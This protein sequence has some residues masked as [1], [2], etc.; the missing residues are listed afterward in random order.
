MTL[1]GSDNHETIYTT[2]FLVQF[3]YKIW[4]NS[5]RLNPLLWRGP[6]VADKIARVNVTKFLSSG[7]GP[8]RVF[9]SLLNYGL[10]IIDGVIN[11]HSTY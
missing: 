11:M 10:A 2:D 9:Q 7:E 3:D 5:R 6:G 8:K 4:K 1:S